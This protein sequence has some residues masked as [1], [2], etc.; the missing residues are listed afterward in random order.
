[1]AYYGSSPTTEA[2][3]VFSDAKVPLLGTI[4]GAGS[5]R[6]PVN[7]Y[8]PPPRELFRR[9]RI[10]RQWPRRA[11]HHADRGVLPERRL[12]QSGKDGVVAPSPG[13]SS[14][15]WPKARSGATRSRSKA[16]LHRSPTNPQA[17]IMVTLFKPT[18]EF[19]RQMRKA[20]VITAVLRCRRSAQTS[21][22]PKWAPEAGTSAF[23][24]AMPYPGTTLPVVKEYHKAL[25][26]FAKHGNYSYLAQASSTPS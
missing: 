17:V 25:Q 5:L 8:V 22:L 20:G 6:T 13:T 14:S 2:M 23:P 9:D 26:A 21:W 16:P 4:S 18:A 11:R 12:R 24:K 7:R 1:M 3:K 10:H 19:V 15:R